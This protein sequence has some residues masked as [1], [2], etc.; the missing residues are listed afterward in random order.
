MTL[1]ARSQEEPGDAQP[2]A[3]PPLFLPQARQSKSDMGSQTEPG[4]QLILWIF[5]YG[6]LG[7]NINAV[8]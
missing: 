8:G 1:F 5:C 6:L 2:E 4:N 3:L 7:A